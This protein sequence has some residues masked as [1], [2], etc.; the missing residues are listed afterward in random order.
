MQ[1][2]DI[3]ELITNLNSRFCY[4]GVSSLLKKI[5]IVVIEFS[6]MTRFLKKSSS[7]TLK[8]ITIVI[9]FSAHDTFLEEIFIRYIQS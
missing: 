9:E 3:L 4:V 7:G 2:L 6:A 1:L 8:V 5:Q